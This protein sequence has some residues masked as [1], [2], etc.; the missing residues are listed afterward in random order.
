[1]AAPITPVPIHPMRVTPGWARAG[2]RP[3]VVGMPHSGR[4]G[5]AIRRGGA[6]RTPRGSDSPAERCA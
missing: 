3:G 2:V 1:M 4:L 5:D 6:L